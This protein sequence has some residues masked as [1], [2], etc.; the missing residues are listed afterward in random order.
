MQQW[1]DL[2]AAACMTA[3]RQRGV[4]K[5]EAIRCA[6]DSARAHREPCAI[7]PDQTGPH[8]GRARAARHTSPG[9]AVR[10]W[11]TAAGLQRA[12]G[13]PLSHPGGPS[14]TQHS[15]RMIP[16]NTTGKALCAL[17][18]HIGASIS[19]ERSLVEARVS[20]AWFAASCA[21]CGGCCLPSRPSP[22]NRMQ[23]CAGGAVA[24]AARR[25]A[26]WRAGALTCGVQILAG[27]RAA[28]HANVTVVDPAS[29]ADGPRHSRGIACAAPPGNGGR[30][31][32]TGYR[33]LQRRHA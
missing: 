23:H 7:G 29:D 18:G 15:C 1:R 30:R 24:E 14:A 16:P 25:G 2:T 31:P 4:W 33:A 8:L 22:D 6:L 26:H 20:V 21:Q 27:R 9:K 13:R 11:G 5:S 17:G 12:C 19:A 10:S 28:W 3:T 32:R